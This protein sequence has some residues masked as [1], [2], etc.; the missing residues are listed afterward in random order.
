MPSPRYTVRLPQ[1]LDA[2]VQARVRTG[3]PFAVLI[4]EALSAYLAD[5]P[6]T[7]IAPTDADTLPTPPIP[8]GADSADSVHALGE[9]FAILRTRVEALEQVLTRRRQGADTVPTRADRPPTGRR[10]GRRSPHERTHVPG[11]DPEAAAARIAA[12]R[13]EGCSLAQ[14]AER[15]NEEQVPTRRGLPW[16]KAL[17]GWFLKHHG[18]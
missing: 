15:L 3:T 1:A 6:P 16:K 10:Q 17:V 11:Y 18:Q 2:L 7:A 13:S 12:L 14:I 4:R 9:Q 8:T 5:T